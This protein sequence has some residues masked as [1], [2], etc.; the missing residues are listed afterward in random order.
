LLDVSHTVL[1]DIYE[2][3][4]ILVTISALPSSRSVA[5][6]LK[7]VHFCC[8]GTNHVEDHPIFKDASIIIT[9]S[10]GMHGPPIAEWAWMT[11]LVHSHRYNSLYELQKQ[12]VWGR[13]DDFGGVRDMVGQRAGILGYGSIG[14]QGRFLPQ[15]NY[16]LLVSAT[17]VLTA[18]LPLVARLGKAMGMEVYAFT[19]TRKDG[20]D[21]RRDNGYI[22]PGTGDPDGILPDKW[23]SG[24]DTPS[25]HDFLGQDLDLLFLCLPL[26]SVATPRPL[27]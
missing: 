5:P 20:P 14:R 25:L 24:L 23:F 18:Y 17:T 12:H 11:A 19:A 2:D 15:G 22:V 21:S 3:K 6:N 7:L 13:H 9:T 26:R 1:I 27:V 4:T 16:L 8:A 10:S